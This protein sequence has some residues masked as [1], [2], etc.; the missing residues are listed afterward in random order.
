MKPTQLL[1]LLLL[2][3]FTACNSA[4]EKTAKISET[5]KSDSISK[6]A[7]DS[8]FAWEIEEHPNGNM[9]FLDVP[10]TLDGKTEYLSL[11]VAK[12]FN[13]ARP[14]FISVMIPKEL[15]DCQ[16]MEIAFTCQN[17]EVVNSFYPQFEKGKEDYCVFRMNNA[18]AKDIGN[19]QIDI[20]QSFLTFETVAFIF[21]QKKGARTSVLV[22]LYTF[23][24]V[25]N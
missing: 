1:I 19:M 24:E 6:A 21:E 9:Y 10:F 13:E 2:F 15:N 18:Y 3:L 25:Y 16:N 4:N 23:K 22:P 20:I 17:K 7:I 14:A 12:R 11:T 5:D 8:L